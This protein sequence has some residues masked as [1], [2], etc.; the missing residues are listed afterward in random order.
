MYLAGASG[1]ASAPTVVLT[2]NAGA[3]Q[4]GAFTLTIT[5]SQAVTG[6]VVG[7]ITYSYC[8]LSAFATSDNT[9]FTCTVTPQGVSNNISLNV[10][11]GVCVGT[12]GGLSN[13]ASNTLTITQWNPV[14]IFGANLDMEFNFRNTTGKTLSGLENSVLGNTT[15]EGNG[16]VAWTSV[17]SGGNTVKFSGDWAYAQGLNG[18]E[19]TAKTG[20][21]YLHDGTNF[22]I[23]CRVFLDAVG[24]AYTCHII[25]NNNGTSANR[26]ISFLINVSSGNVAT[27]SFNTT[28]GPGVIYNNSSIALGTVPAGGSWYT[29]RLTKTGSGLGVGAATYSLYLDGV[30]KLSAVNTGAISG[31]AA[32]C[33]DNLTIFR[34][35][36]TTYAYS[37]NCLIKDLCF[38]T[39][40]L[41][42]GQVT[43]MTNYLALGRETFYSGTTRYLFSLIGQ[44]LVDGSTPSSTPPSYLQDALGA[45]IFNPTYRAS[46]TIGDTFQN[47]DYGINQSAFS[48][49]Y[50]GPSLSFGYQANLL[51]PGLIY[52]SQTAK[53]ATPWYNVAGTD[54][55]WSTANAS[56]LARNSINFVMTAHSLRIHKYQLNSN[57]KLFLYINEG[58]TD[59]LSANPDAVGADQTAKN[60][61]VQASVKLNFTNYLKKYIDDIR[62]YGFD[63]VNLHI[64]TARIIG[65][66][67]P[68]TPNYTL[69]VNAAIDNVV[70][71]FA[72]DNPT[73]VGKYATLQS[74]NM[75]YVNLGAS[76]GTHPNDADQVTQG[77]LICT[78]LSPYF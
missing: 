31:S 9:V 8:F 44:S 64:L 69:Y 60:A 22:E 50:Y 14:T 68:T 55:C 45:Y 26:G 77:Q 1:G 38:L 36:S 66:F 7:D 16:A 54:T 24:A 61:A 71:N 13:S 20:R 48:A 11:A 78:N 10:G 47:L 67:N 57:V 42:A 65:S 51:K 58:Q 27:G 33:T 29:L 43:S 18:I 15:A 74:Q 2:S 35:S 70:A 76:D 5:F 49:T 52:I 23:W 32:D 59:C 17:A 72:T 6:F 3:S 25:Q 63:T 73:Y 56:S 28:N 34:T 12:V 39:T 30:S 40:S 62:T 53:G 46:Y 41:S 21:R 75:D 19:S 4:E 37:S